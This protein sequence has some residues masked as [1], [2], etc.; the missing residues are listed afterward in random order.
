[1]AI[2]G[3]GLR[4][5]GFMNDPVS[6][7]LTD[8]GLEHY[9]EAFA[10]HAITWDVLPE[11]TDEDL[12][13]L[14]VLLGH[15]KKL[16]RAIAQLV[17]QG[18]GDP[19]AS[20]A[21]RSAQPSPPSISRNQAERRQLTVMFCDLVGSTALASR[22]D[23]EELQPIIRRFLDACSHAVGRGHGYI[24]KYMGDG[25]LA[26]FGY[27]HAHEHDAERAIHAGLAVLELVKA[28][29]L[30]GG[31]E[32]NI[33]VRIG[34]ATGHVLVGELIGTDT[35]QERSVFGE[36]PN[37]AAR[38]QSLA[39][40]N[41]LIVDMT[42]KQLVGNEFDFADCGAVALKGF[43]LPVQAW[44]VVGRNV[45]VSRFESYRAD[46][47]ANFIGR[48]SEIALLLTRWREAVEGEGRVVFLSGEAGI[49]KSK[50]VWQL[51]AELTAERHHT[52]QLQ[53]SPHHTK[54]ALYPVINHLRW[55]FGLT[56]E[57]SPATRLEK[58]KAFAADNGLHD[59]TRLSVL[60]D[61]FSIPGGELSLTMP[62]SPDKRK[63]LVLDALVQLLRNRAERCPTLC[64]VEDIHWIDPTSMELL[65]RVISSI[66]RVSALLV[67]T[68]RPDFQPGWL[69][70]NHVMVLTLSRLSRRESADLLASA[71]GGKALPPEVTETILAKT[72]GVP[73]YV[74][75]LVDSVIKSGF[76][77]E[78]HDAFSLKAPLT[79]FPIPDS[80]QALLTERIDRLG[81]AKEVAQIGAALGREFAYE[82]LRELVD[83]A[84]RELEPA[85]HALSKSGLI[86][87]E[88]E[89]ALAKYVFRHA[90]IQDAAYGMLPKAS[91]RTLHS[92][93]AQVLESKFAERTAREPELLAHHYEQA[94]LIRPAITY[95]FLAAQRDAAR[96]ACI[97]ALYHF[98]K[99]LDLVA[100]VPQ[101]SERTSLELDFLVA[102]GP[103][104]VSLKGYAADETEH[105]YSRLEELSQSSNNP[106]HYF[107][108]LWGLWIFHLV[109]GSLI[110]AG[111]LADRLLRWAHHHQNQEFLV[112]AHTAMGTTYSFHGRFVE[113]K[114]HFGTA[115]AVFS[116]ARSAPKTH[117]SQPLGYIA[118]PGIAARIMTA[119]A[120]LMSGEVDQVEVLV[121]EALGMARKLEHPFTLA[122]ALATAPWVYSI[123]RDAGRT[124]ILAEEGITLSTKYSFEVPLAY[125]TFFQG[126]AMDTMEKDEGLAR[127]LVGLSAVRA[128]KASLN[129]THMLA[130]LAE[131]YL[132]K[133][134]ID[135]GLGVIDEAFTLVHA[136]GETC[137][138]AELYRLKGELLL[139]Q[140]KR[141]ISVAEQCF[142]E[143]MEIAQSQQAML[144][145]LR[146]AMSLA[147]LLE[148]QNKLDMAKGT[149]SSVYSRFGAHGANPDLAD[150]R[151]LLDRLP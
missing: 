30:E 135:E 16:R 112:R 79:D 39:A 72:E 88:G 81:L 5:H 71:T 89:G 83:V 102:R 51:G 45:S 96:S 107:L 25:L 2:L 138:H 68:A 121:Q 100:R 85:L 143:A 118:E 28:L 44:Q 14:G 146:A 113:A 8:L 95:W 73:L 140:S 19:T 63:E 24:A 111:D 22:L 1:M 128:T 120:L 127:I 61:L 15:R 29:P 97:E 93:I 54:A 129:S 42:T 64:I 105:N 106:E 86:V 20:Q 36:T 74:E 53:C 87:E 47:R 116:S 69:G 136:Q 49:G 145:E 114:R 76:L 7:W 139:A 119:R 104:I 40:P 55:A 46:R 91:R 151:A 80:L 13:S 50:L 67:I 43:D 99:A 33:A 57:D 37:L 60:G 6:A 75:E 26:Y 133:K 66:Q 141:C 21:I 12:T 122:F 62:L 52:I 27:P 125:L 17:Q 3:H 115:K 34:I 65:T 23:P 103:V 130:L 123:L 132:R 82:L 124:L 144:L 58:L 4:E 78:G 11:L 94:E 18:V 10:Q 101:D 149:L 35:V 41:Q 38:L 150:A 32:Q 48:E 92:R 56:S 90:L 108:A 98:D 77:I 59:P 70:L 137:W 131:V 9:Q 142:V 126:W 148:K 147:R 109:R 110:T 134:R 117:Q 84:E 31:G